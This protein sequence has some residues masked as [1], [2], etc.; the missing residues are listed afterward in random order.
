MT[1]KDDNPPQ[2][3]TPD[4]LTPQKVLMVDDDKAMRTLLSLMLK[5]AK[6]SVTLFD[7]AKEALEF[8]EQTQ[9][10]D[11]IIVDYMLPGMNG[12]DLVRRIREIPQW[13][14]IRI[15]ML[16]ARGDE[17][18]RSEAFEAGVNKYLVKPLLIHNISDLFT[19]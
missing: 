17:D 1:N 12:V 13:K 16:S 5:R 3:Q 19:D 11:M 18:A 15:V 9:E 8:L 6:H 10:L 14:A 7:I 4:A 2:N